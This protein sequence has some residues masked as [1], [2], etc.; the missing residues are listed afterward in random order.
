M[1]VGLSHALSS[2]D[3][4]DLPHY[5]HPPLIEV[6]MGVHWQL[7]GEFPPGMQHAL[8]ERLGP[9]WE[10]APPSSRPP[11]ISQQDLSRPWPSRLS[12]HSLL[13]DQR[14]EISSEGLWYAWDGRHGNIYPH[15]ETVRD[16]FIIALDVW[17]DAS[18]NFCL[19]PPTFTTWHIA[20]LNCI[21]QGTV[22]N[23]LSDC[24]FLRLLAPVPAGLPPLEHCKA[25]W[26]FALP[27]YAAQLMCQFHTTPGTPHDDR[28][29]IWLQLSCTGSLS[30]DPSTLLEGLDYGRQHIVQAF[31]QLMSPAANN[32][33]ELTQPT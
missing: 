25:C 22:W 15:Y 33:W 23:D 6:V 31:R 9:S 8:L 16:G 29:H 11:T 17:Q 13:R 26:R 7:P 19:A 14:L 28:A 24:T 27:N 10:L 12:F 1:P 20:Y 3:T 4:V 18:A 30:P 21:P 2:T 5:Q 32:Y